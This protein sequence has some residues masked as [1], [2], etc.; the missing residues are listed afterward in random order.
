MGKTAHP[1]AKTEASSLSVRD[2]ARHAKSWLLDGEVR[3]LSPATLAGR[4]IVLDKLIWFAQQQEFEEVGLPELRA[5]LAYLSNGH[6]SESGR[7]GNASLKAK[8]KPGTVQ[9]YHARLRTFFEFLI[10]EGTIDSSPMAKLL[11]PVNRPDQIVPFTDE[12]IEALQRAAKKSRHP[13]RDMAIVLFLLDTGVRASELCSLLIGDL[14]MQTRR[15]LIAGKG[16]KRRSV[17]FGAV[18][19]KALWSYIREQDRSDDQ[20]VF[21]ADRGGKA[22]DGLTRSGLLQLCERLGKAAGI[23]A[24]RCSPHTFRH[25]FAISFLR[26]GGNQFSL[27]Q[28]LGHTS[29]AMTAVYLKLAQAD[30]ERQHRQY[31]PVDRLRRNGK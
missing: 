2:L 17:Y 19:L 28:L 11:P 6:G 14:D 13:K 12:Q 16:G 3:Q 24:A 18:T 23:E 10:S 22:G 8:A 7:W 9:T 15:C 27:M 31:S 4:K 26:A 25:T 20:P 29:L 21:L 5:F 1:L 30:L